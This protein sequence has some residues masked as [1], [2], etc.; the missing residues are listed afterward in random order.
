MKVFVGRDNRGSSCR[1]AAFR[2]RVS[3]KVEYLLRKDD[4]ADNATHTG[5]STIGLMAFIDAGLVLTGQY[6]GDCI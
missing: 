1:D 4:G 3:N 2:R 6:R 5:L